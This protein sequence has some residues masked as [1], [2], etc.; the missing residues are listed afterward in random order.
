MSEQEN[1]G[2]E[3]NSTA[4]D[5]QNQLGETNSS[6]QPSKAI[7]DDESPEEEVVEVT[8]D[9]EYDRV[10]NFA[11]QQN[12]VPIIKRLRLVNG[13]AQLTNV[14]IGSLLTDNFSAPSEFRFDRVARAGE[15]QLNQIDLRLNPKTLAQQKE[16]EKLEI[17]IKVSCQEFAARTFTFPI[18]ILAVNEWPGINTLPEILAAFVFP[19]SEVVT[20]ILAKAL[21][22]HEERVASPVF[23]G[24]Q[25]NDVAGVVAQVRSIY[26]ALALEGLGYV[27]GPPSFEEQG[28]K[29]RL[30][31]DIIRHRLGN[32]LDLTLLTAAVF[33]QAG[34]SPV[35]FILKGH[36]LCGV[37]TSNH[38]FA[39]P[40]VDDVATLRKRIDVED[41]I[42]L[43]TTLLTQRPLVPFHVARSDGRQHLDKDGEFLVAI[44]IQ[45]SR[46]LKIRPMSLRLDTASQVNDE[47]GSATARISPADLAALNA[48]DDS[49]TEIFRTPAV[50]HIEADAG[51]HAER[52]RI[53]RWQRKLLDLSLRNRLL[54]FRDT[55]KNL[56]LLIPDPAAFDNALE[57]NIVFGLRGR[58]ALNDASS[59][60]D[61]D[62]HK[63][64]TH[65]DAI[66]EFLVAD[67]EA[68]IVHADVSS[69]EVESRLLDLYRASKNSLEETGAN[70]LYLALGFL[71]WFETEDSRIDRHAPIILIPM[72]LTRKSVQ[73]GFRLRRGDDDA[74]MNTTLLEKLKQDFDIATDS[75]QDLPED[76][77]GID[78]DLVLKN[79]RK[80]I[81]DVPRW[82]IRADAAIGLFSFN[83]FLMWM[84]LEEHTEQ[85]TASKVVGH[86]VNSPGSSF[87]GDAEFPEPSDLDE[88][89]PRSQNLCPLDADSSQL[90]AIIAAE[91]GR[92][93]VLQGP[94]GT[95]KSQTITNLIAHS[96]AQGKRVLF[97]AEKMAALNVVHSRLSRIGLASSCLEL[98]SNKTS[99]RHVLAQLEEAI[100]V[101]KTKDVS[102]WD[103]LAEELTARRNE[104]NAYVSEVHT[105]YAPGLS[106]YQ[107]TSRLAGRKMEQSV[108]LEIATN[109]E[110]QRSELDELQDL[111]DALG[112]ASERTA[113]VSRHPLRSMRVQ[114]WSPKLRSR[115]EEAGQAILSASLKLRA[116]R[117]D[118]NAILGLP[119]SGTSDSAFQLEALGQLAN[120][121]LQ[122]A[123]TTR[124]LLSEPGWTA[125]EET[126]NESIRRGQALEILRHK[127]ENKYTDELLA[128][129][130]APWIL[131]LQKARSSIP[132]FSW[133]KI[134]FTKRALRPFARSP[135]PDTD[136]LVIDLSRIQ[137]VRAEVRHLNEMSDQAKRFFGHHWR[138][139]S[140][141]W[142]VLNKIL[143]WSKTF[144]AIVSELTAT[145]EWVA[146]GFRERVLALAV[147]ES[148]QFNHQSNV[149]SSIE[150]YVKVHHQL[151]LRLEA[152][153]D[154]AELDREI[155]FGGR[156]DEGFLQTLE[157][158]IAQQTRGL[159]S[160]REWCHWCRLIAKANQKGL[161][162]LADALAGETIKPNDAAHVFEKSFLEGWLEA[163]LESSDLLRRFNSR[164]HERKIRSFAD[165]DEKLLA[166]SSDVI[167]ARIN[168]HLPGFSKEASSK[169]EV[170]ILQ[171]QLKLKRRHMPI[172]KLFAALPDLLPRLKP[173]LLMSP[174]SVAQYLS[175]DYPRADI[176]VFDEASQIPVWDAIG[177]LARGASAVVV[178]DSK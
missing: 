142:D 74:R 119:V 88:V 170:G 154:L 33:E 42:V 93:F 5:R 59:P 177:A 139:A 140:S 51:N 4:P 1:D 174:L 10:V 125:I 92:T 124:A 64:R 62:V 158:T 144:R 75:L 69:Q 22:I 128:T 23:D 24:Y 138:G 143:A 85:L 164:D 48:A 162:N 167:R 104:L 60:R 84:D 65:N 44:D 19:N 155:A 147:E 46:K 52:S 71:T 130:V 176:V 106:I 21:R 47:L 25:N 156:T 8:L 163:K 77:N 32:C 127:V 129:D 135:L 141:D 83:K 123:G 172:R 145:P 102:E 173:C 168:S 50:E 3:V 110:I 159:G 27:G 103:A 63:E 122:N 29:V 6:N 14:V 7:V 13:P 113:P 114:E 12:A 111:A 2:A 165:L 169:S 81:M 109:H 94:P 15:L 78:V 39:E 126:L 43:E 178:G 20:A 117:L 17:K 97:V 107:A 108:D 80:A 28:Q 91:Q 161:K 30:P 152:F 82:D 40:T 76:E 57:S 175:V 148:D 157:S 118:L 55:K 18:E 79:F 121:L 136:S 116:A 73:D 66:E 54:N 120:L 151:D 146:S 68:H 137:K 70:S 45:A 131:S 150:E 72:E 34:L 100:A 171:R 112:T 37:W 86:L 96:L 38:C 53:D 67:L 49:K 9:L 58:P 11:M 95:G 132:P 90:R 61:L 26:E 87:E 115:L 153:D 99:K 105:R 36:A 35:V 149:R 166:L 134:F 41:I 133:L 31:E 160:L 98:H 56:R 16:R 89:L 101:T